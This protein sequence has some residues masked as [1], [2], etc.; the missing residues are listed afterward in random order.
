MSNATLP[1][2]IQLQAKGS[3]IISPENSNT[4][5]RN[6][7]VIPNKSPS[8]SNKDLYL[9]ADIVGEMANTHETL[10]RNLILNQTAEHLEF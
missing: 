9:N 5:S 6:K 1:T 10:G 3:Q 8:S 7:L 2:H 4:N